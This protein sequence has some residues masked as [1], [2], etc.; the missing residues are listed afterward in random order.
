M[1]RQEQKL[2]TAV[3]HRLLLTSSVSLKKVL[4]VPPSKMGIMIRTRRQYRASIELMSGNHLDLSSWR[5][6]HLPVTITNVVKAQLSR[7][8]SVRGNLAVHP[9]SLVG[10]LVSLVVE[11]EEPISRGGDSAY[12]P[13]SL[14]R[15]VRTCVQAALPLHHWGPAGHLAQSQPFLSGAGWVWS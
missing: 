11:A 14:S 8:A 1:W 6:R 5:S 12:L 15:S 4:S 3:C 10:Q 7:A 13:S 9:A 2:L